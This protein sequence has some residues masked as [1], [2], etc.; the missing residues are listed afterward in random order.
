MEET[1]FRYADLLGGIYVPK[2]EEIAA[3]CLGP[4]E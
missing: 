3:T 4:R 1:K 2:A